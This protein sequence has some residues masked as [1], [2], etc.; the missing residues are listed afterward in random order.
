MA[1]WDEM[2]LHYG[3][4]PVTQVSNISNTVGLGKTLVEIYKY[5]FPFASTIFLVDSCSTVSRDL[6]F[7]KLLS[8]R[9]TNDARIER[10]AV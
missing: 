6:G 9:H 3:G 10:H 1:V 4:F 5:L 7:P 2:N 8:L